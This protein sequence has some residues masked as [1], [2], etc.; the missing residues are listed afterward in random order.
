MH[1]N[2]LNDTTGKMSK[3]NNDFLTLNG[4]IKK[5]YNPLAYRYFLLMTHY[6]KEITFS[7]EA[8]DAA[9]VA[10]EKLTTFV[11][12]FYI[13]NEKP[14][15]SYM[16][17]AR[18]LLADDLA[19]PQVIAL[20]FKLIKDNNVVLTV[21]AATIVEIGNLLGL[22]FKKKVN[23]A[24]VEPKEVTTLLIKRAEA[25]KN[26]DFSLSDALRDEIATHGFIVKDTPSGQELIKA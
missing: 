7:Y 24:I 10:Y 12:T 6:R 9:S 18:A 15:I 22:D 13:E 4:L 5:G 2:F 11:H 23:S 19:T 14:D 20:M 25:R 21:Q 17:E 26:K 3:S 8:L 1:V 16:N